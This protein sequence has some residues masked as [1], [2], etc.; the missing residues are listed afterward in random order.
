MKAN[1][2]INYDSSADYQLPPG[3]L[4]WHC[5]FVEK[6]MLGNFHIENHILIHSPN[7][8]TWYQANQKAQIAIREYFGGD[9]ILPPYKVSLW[10]P[11]SL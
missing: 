5:V 11:V 10:E 1:P 3:E 2:R 4:W 8:Q 9:C 7:I 6:S